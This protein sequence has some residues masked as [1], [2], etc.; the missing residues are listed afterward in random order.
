MLA[1]THWEAGNKEKAQ[2]LFAEIKQNYKEAID[3]RA[4]PMTELVEA[5]EKELGI[6][7]G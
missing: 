1:L 5:A 7:K 4:R 2:Q 6:A 3:H